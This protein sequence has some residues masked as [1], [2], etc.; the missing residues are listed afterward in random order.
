MK[1]RAFHEIAKPAALGVGAP[2]LAVH[3]PEGK[4]L[5]DFIH[6][7]RIVQHFAQVAPGRAAVALQ[8]L[9]AGTVRYLGRGL[10]RLPN[11]RPQSRDQAEPLA[12]VFLIHRLLSRNLRTATPRR[13]PVHSPA[14]RTNAE[15]APRS[16]YFAVDDSLARI[17]VTLARLLGNRE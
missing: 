3:Q 9:L 11:Q 6:G 8:Q 16:V 1:E 17:P 2:Q 13:L 10:M 5:E 15:N 14:C 4:L 7:V 12:G